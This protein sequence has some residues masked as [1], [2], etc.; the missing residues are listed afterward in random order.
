MGGGKREIKSVDN[1]F[2]PFGSE[3]K[4]EWWL[5]GDFAQGRSFL[6]GGNR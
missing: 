5:E 6:V 2:T 4:R 3:R 1:F